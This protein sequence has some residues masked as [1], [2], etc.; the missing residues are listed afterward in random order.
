MPSD[1]PEKCLAQS[2]QEKLTA[3]TLHLVRDESQRAKFFKSKGGGARPAPP[4]GSGMQKKYANGSGMQKKYAKGDAQAKEIVENK[5]YAFTM[6]SALGQ[7]LNRELQNPKVKKQFNSAPDVEEWKKQWVVKQYADAVK[8]QR[9]FTT[10]LGEL[11]QEWQDGRLPSHVLWDEKT[12]NDCYT[13]CTRCISMGYPFVAVD[14]QNGSVKF[15][16][17]SQEYQEKFTQRWS[18]TETQSEKKA[19]CDSGK[20]AARKT[21]VIKNDGEAEGPDDEPEEEDDEEEPA[22][23]GGAPPAGSKTGKKT[24]SEATK[25]LQQARRVIVGLQSVLQSSTSLQATIDEDVGEGDLESKGDDWAWARSPAVIGRIRDAHAKIDA[26]V[27][28][29]KLWNK[30]MRGT[31]L[32]TAKKGLTDSEIE[33]LCEPKA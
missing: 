22:G 30:I 32:N 5:T 18:E 20:A 17:F 2:L 7:R 27:K 14:E 19:I 11:D 25:R 8:R 12:I 21:P 4:D 33:V 13:A 31:E 1:T 6:R 28:S 29:N 26:T 16:W 23:G 9:Q 3:E 15:M 24:A 10:S